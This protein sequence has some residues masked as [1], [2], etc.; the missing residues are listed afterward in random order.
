MPEASLFKTR[1]TNQL[2]FRQVYRW[3]MVTLKWIRWNYLLVICT[4]VTLQLTFSSLAPSWNWCLGLP[5]S[6]G[7]F[8]DPSGSTVS[9]LLGSLGRAKPT[10]THWCCHRTLRELKLLLK[11]STTFTSYC[12]SSV[13][14]Q[15]NWLIYSVV[16]AIWCH[17]FW[18]LFQQAIKN[19]A[20]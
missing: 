14:L 13:N 12:T 4:D 3:V 10:H 1:R 6:G 11:T 17:S 8:K 2:Q 7:V 16:L 20:L 18:W 9:L 15:W 5:E 19:V